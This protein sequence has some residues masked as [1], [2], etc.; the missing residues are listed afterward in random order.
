MSYLPTPNESNILTALRAFLLAVLPS[1]IEVLR[2]QENLIPEPSGPDF[3][4]MTSL[5]NTRLAT[6]VRIDKDVSFT[7]S[8]AGT[9]MTVTATAFGT[10]Q[11]GQTVFGT[12]VTP[13][14]KITSVSGPNQYI[15]TPSQTVT[16]QKLASGGIYITQPLQCSYQL[17][18]HGPNSG[19]NATTI[20]TL[21]RDDYGVQL[22]KQSGFDVTPFYADDPR[23]L[24]FGNENAQIE[25]RWIIT[26]VV[27]ANLTVRAPQQYAD[28]LSFENI[29]DADI[30]F[31]A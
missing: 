23:Q 31:P 28:E 4:L 8:I 19:D 5:F 24:I 21:F 14:T 2:A 29:Y 6:N 10:I 26:A 9:L 15:V 16:S 22:F 13:G 12:G 11:S 17:D 27:Q 7:G 18:V 30:N 1:G 25:Q 3:V 20:T